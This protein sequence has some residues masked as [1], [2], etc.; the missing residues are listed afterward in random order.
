MA[1][2]LVLPAALQL[3][4]LDAP[5][6]RAKQHVLFVAEPSTV[7]AGRRSTLELKFRVENGFHVNSHTPKSDLQ[8]AT[9]V[10][11]N[12]ADGVKLAAAEYPAGKPYVL[13]ADPGDKLDVYA[14]EFVVKVPVEASA[15]E[16][17]LKGELVYQACDRAA[18]Y[19]PRKLPLD[20]VFK[21]R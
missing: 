4:L 3:G 1:L 14:D 19:P 20:V 16:H 11:L 8:I 2:C 7:A 12:P 13:D 6:V 18:C 21:A 9:V 10:T 17:E 5:Q 15:G